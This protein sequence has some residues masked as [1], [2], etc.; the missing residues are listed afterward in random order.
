VKELAPPGL[1]L[2]PGQ[3]DLAE[4]LES[5]EAVAVEPEQDLEEPD[6]ALALEHQR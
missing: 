2:E 5:G 1:A 4:P 3:D 6:P